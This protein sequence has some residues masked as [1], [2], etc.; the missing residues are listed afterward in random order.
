M[1]SPDR[2]SV[3]QATKFTGQ[4]DLF[5]AP[6]ADQKGIILGHEPDGSSQSRPTCGQI[7]T[8]DIAIPRGGG[9]QA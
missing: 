4:C 9:H 2:L 3:P 5:Q 6:H 7:H 1:R 8:Q